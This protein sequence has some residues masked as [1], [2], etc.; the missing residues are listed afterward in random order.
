MPGCVVHAFILLLLQ[1]NQHRR[2]GKAP[3]AGTVRT[4]PYR[5]HFQ[6]STAESGLDPI[7]KFKSGF[8]DFENWMLNEKAGK[9][10][11]PRQKLA[12]SNV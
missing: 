9:L 10:L 12:G 4:A 11:P 2:T 3:L 1:E 6:V 8:V 7:G 5:R